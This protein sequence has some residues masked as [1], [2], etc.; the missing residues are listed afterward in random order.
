M[1]A[2]EW[3][4]VQLHQ[5]KGM[6]S[7]SPPTICNS[8]VFN[9]DIETCSGCGGA[10]KVIACIED[11]IVIKQILDHLKHKAET[12]G[13]RALPESRAPPAELLLGLFD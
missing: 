11:P 8:A 3:V 6:I 4:H 10:M 12:S 7:L 2:F 1:P 5:Q 9:I 13:T